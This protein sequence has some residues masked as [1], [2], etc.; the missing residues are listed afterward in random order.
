MTAVEE[1]APTR[2]ELRAILANP[3]STQEQV[4][5][6][7]LILAKRIANGSNA[8]REICDKYHLTPEQASNLIAQHSSHSVK[9]EAWAK[10]EVQR[11]EQL[12]AELHG[13]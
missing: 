9:R 7:K 1:P 11:L 12:L 8:T 6:V 13:E 2:Q 3:D 5:R 10:E 4:L